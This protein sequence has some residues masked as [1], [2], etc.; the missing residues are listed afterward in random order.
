MPKAEE[1][2]RAA[3]VAAIAEDR[4]RFL[5]ALEAIVVADKETTAN[6]IMTYLG[7]ARVVLMD[8]HHGGI[9]NEEQNR[10]HSS[11]ISAEESKWAVLAA[12]DVY[13]LLEGLSDDNTAPDIPQEKF[14]PTL[15][16]TVGYLLSW[17]AESLGYKSFYDFLD[18]VLTRVESES[19]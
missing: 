8:I 19:D 1:L 16:L 15:F 3:V 5:V 17:Y 7:V 4:D 11:D 13:A 12:N 2:G 14:L 9:P 6:A 18:V 10:I